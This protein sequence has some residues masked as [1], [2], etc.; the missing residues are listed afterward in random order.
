M[1]AQAAKPSDDLGK[2][3]IDMA[4][5]VLDEDACG[6]HFVNDPL[7]VRPK[8]ARV[9]MSQPLPGP[10]ER[11]ARISGREDMN[12]AA[13]GPAVEGFEIVPDRRLI[14]GLV[15]HPGHESGRSVGFPLDETYSP[16]GGLGDREAE[17]ETTVTG[18]Q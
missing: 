10:T 4:F 16:I 14:Q 3:Q 11:L 8:V 1:V 17:L 9:G 18:T 2:S 5:D 6:A 7:D 15:C 13:P 12:L